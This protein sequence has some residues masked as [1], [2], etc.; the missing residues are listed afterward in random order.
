MV[1]DQVP[2]DTGASLTN[3]QR[4]SFWYLLHL[5]SIVG[6]EFA[7]S[8]GDP[9][10]ILELGR[11]PEEGNGKPL[12]YSCLGNTMTEEPGRL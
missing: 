1:E 3:S 2:Y 11:Y 9:G 6:K 7:C 4:E 12:Q 10:L 5:G 8:A